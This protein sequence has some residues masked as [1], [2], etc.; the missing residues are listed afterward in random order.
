MTP[1]EVINLL[2]P[3][4]APRSLDDNVLKAHSLDYQSF[5]N[6]WIFHSDPTGKIV[7]NNK[8]TG[9]GTVWDVS[10][11][12][13]DNDW[14]CNA[15][16][17]ICIRKNDSGQDVL[18]FRM[19]TTHSQACWLVH[20]EDDY[21]TRSEGYTFASDSNGGPFGSGIPS[22]FMREGDNNIPIH[23]YASYFVICLKEA[24]R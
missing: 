13:S 4:I 10:G 5:P 23:K 21:P 17:N 20:D 22:F 2:P 9:V 18:A 24:V 11:C 7:F 12:A 8:M 6:Y 3:Q 16:N 1:R 19:D 15:E 14:C